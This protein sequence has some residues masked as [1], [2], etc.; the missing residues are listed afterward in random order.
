MQEIALLDKAL[1]QPTTEACFRGS[2]ISEVFNL[3]GQMRRHRDCHELLDGLFLFAVF[4]L[5][6][7]FQSF[8]YWPE[9]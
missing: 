7:D 5:E 8:V 6:V 2:G 4:D 1:D 9:V 3:T